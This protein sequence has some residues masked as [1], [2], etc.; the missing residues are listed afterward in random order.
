MTM[1]ITAGLAG[2]LAST[3]GRAGA[4]NNGEPHGDRDRS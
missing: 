4:D 3:P 2:V 1:K